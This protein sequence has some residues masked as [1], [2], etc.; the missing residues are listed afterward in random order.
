MSRLIPPERKFIA[1][2][3]CWNEAIDFDE[4]CKDHQ[5]CYYCGTREDCSCEDNEKLIKQYNRNRPFEQHIDNVK[6]IKK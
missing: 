4:Y 2:K 3:L 1:C 6:E 5:K